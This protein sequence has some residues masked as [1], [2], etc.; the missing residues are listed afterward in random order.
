VKLRRLKLGYDFADLG[1]NSRVLAILN[2][3]AHRLQPLRAVFWAILFAAGVGFV[4]T[5]TGLLVLTDAYAILFLVS[6]MWALTLL[7]LV[8][9]FPTS[10][11]SFHPDDGVWVHLRKR[12]SYGLTWLIGA[13]TVLASITVVVTTIKLAGIFASHFTN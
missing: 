8:S 5:V 13:A 10:I 6:M 2:K 1:C 3:L 7:V 12:I 4:A 9:C 11:A